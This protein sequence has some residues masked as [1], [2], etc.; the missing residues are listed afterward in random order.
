MSVSD[1]FVIDPYSFV[2]TDQVGRSERSHPVPARHEAGTEQCCDRT[3]ALGPG[4]VYDIGQMC[5][6]YAGCIEKVPEGTEIKIISR[7]FLVINQGIQE[8][9]R[10]H[11]F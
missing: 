2:D 7:S 8:C 1:V 10:V 11:F 4:N 6:G 5:I 9:F 3:L